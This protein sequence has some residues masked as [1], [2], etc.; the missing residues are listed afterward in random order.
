MK[1]GNKYNLVLTLDQYADG[2]V[3]SNK[4]LNLTFNNHDE[5]FAII[6]KL[7]EKDP[8][9]DSSQA[10]QFALGL[11]LF[12]EVLLKN[13]QHPLFEELNNVFPIF[14]KKLKSL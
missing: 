5:I 7:Q 10:A 8:F 9:N 11:K 14:M 13:K 4:K 3:D 6:K 2:S 12:S 1:K